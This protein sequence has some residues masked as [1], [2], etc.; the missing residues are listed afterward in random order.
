[1]L[2]LL[3]CLIIE[4][5]ITEYVYIDNAL[6]LSTITALCIKEDMEISILLYCKFAI[7]ECICM[8]I[9]PKYDS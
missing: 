4:N 2:F 8:S 9:I 7:Q 5:K 6:N 3:P 1:M